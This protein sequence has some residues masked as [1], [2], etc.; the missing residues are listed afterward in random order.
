ML[1]YSLITLLT[2]IVSY[3]TY[4]P[5]VHLSLV[6]DCRWVSVRWW[7]I[8]SSCRWLSTPAPL[9]ILWTWFA[10]S[11]LVI[12]TRFGN[13]IRD[14]K[15]LLFLVFSAWSS[16]CAS[17]CCLLVS[18]SSFSELFDGH[19][20]FQYELCLQTA[21]CCSSFRSEQQSAALR[22]PPARSSP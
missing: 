11:M 4:R 20:C 5:G 14:R 13:P 8:K 10:G 17:S 9:W 15:N 19:L 1:Q 12:E 2:P 16:A 6:I 21:V 7:P 22:S 3:L 18:I